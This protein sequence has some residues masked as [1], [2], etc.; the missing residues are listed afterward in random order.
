MGEVWF[1]GTRASQAVTEIIDT[2][3][4][5]FTGVVELVTAAGRNGV[6]DSTFAY[7]VVGETLTRTRMSDFSQSTLS[8][9]GSD[10][11]LAL[12]AGNDLWIPRNAA[13]TLGLV[14]RSTL[15]LAASYAS[16]NISYGQTGLAWDGNQTLYLASLPAGVSP[17]TRSALTVFNTATNS[18]ANTYTLSTSLSLARHPAYLD[19][20]VYVHHQPTTT[21]QLMKVDSSTGT[22]VA[23]VN[24]ISN[25]GGS[26]TIVAGGSIFTSGL[27]S[28]NVYRIDPSMMTVT[29]TYVIGNSGAQPII[30]T[31][32]ESVWCSALNSS[33]VTKIDG[34]TGSTTT[35]VRPDVT[36]T[37]GGTVQWVSGNYGVKSGIFVGAVVF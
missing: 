13:N 25:Y 21:H 18:I 8:V 20:Y 32:G 6:N 29:D 5:A 31:D 15:T 23:T 24:T 34:A 3:T 19:G 1:S 7:R 36:S 33:T 17:A 35:I 26:R 27:N 12:G 30:T 28:R 37:S 16:L 4:D 11:T 10:L 14:D 9:A 2:T 22:V